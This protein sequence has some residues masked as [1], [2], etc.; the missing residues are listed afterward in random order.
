M[1]NR[2]LLLL[3]SLTRLVAPL[4]VGGHVLTSQAQY[5]AEVLK[6]GPIHY[7]RF[8][9]ASGTTIA[10]GGTPGGAP[11]TI[12]GGVTLGKPSITSALGRAA[13]FDGVNNTFVELG[14]FHPGDSMTVEA[15]ASE[16]SDSSANYRA[17]AARWDG[18][19]ELDLQQTDYGNF[20]VRNNENTFGLAA[21]P[22]PVA[23]EQWNHLVGVFDAVNGFCAIYINGVLAESKTIAGVLQDNNRSP[24]DRVFIGATRTGVY[25]WKGLIDEVA[26]YDKA[27][28]PQRIKAHYDAALSSIKPP[29]LAIQTAALITWPN[30][31]PNYILQVSESLNEPRQ[32]LAVTDKISSEGGMFKLCLPAIGNKKFFRLFKP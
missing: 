4:L 29:E 16:D 5:S 32:W 20:V 17:I 27:L 18:S 31:S 1:N 19:Y 30:F 24:I 6:D 15:W 25:C 28:T 14:V 9:E 26:F 22:K 7:Y 8:E 21:T 23:R 3:T 11:G 10:D 2:S 12:S 13:H